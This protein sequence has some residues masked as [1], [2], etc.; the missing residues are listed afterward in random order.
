MPQSNH[1]PIPAPGPIT[2]APAITAVAL[3]GAGPGDPGL[4]TLRGAELLRQ[5]E[6]VVYDHLANPR[7]LAM[8]PTARQIYVGKQAGSHAME[9]DAINA[10]LVA[11]AR[12]GRRVV[13]LKGG[14]P[15][16]FG[17]GGEE[18]QALATAGVPF[19][20]VP[21]ITAAIAA[22][23]YAGIPVTHRDFNSSFTLV[24]GN[25]KE[26]GADSDAESKIDW[27]AL[28]R[29]P[30]I[31]FYM[32][33]AALPRICQR[34][35]EH[36]M[37]PSTPAATIQSGTTGRQRT[38][39]ATLRDLPARVAAAG[40]RAPAI[41]I[42][43][44]VVTLRAAIGWFERRLLFGKTIVVTRTRHQAGELSAKLTE[45]GADVIEA[46]TIELVPPSDFTA[47]DAAL[48]SLATDQGADWVIFTSINGVAAVKARLAAIGLDVRA[49]GRSRIAAIG[50]PTAAAITQQLCLRVDLC[51]EQFVAESLADELEKGGHVAGRR[52]LLLRADITRPVLV[53][54]LRAAGAADVRDISV[55][56]TR[57]AAALPDELRTALRE[58]R[59]D[60]ITFA[61][62]GTATN[63]VALLG[64]DTAHLA[65]IRTASIGPITSATLRQLSLPPTAEAQPSTIDGLIAAIVAATPASPTPEADSTSDS[66]F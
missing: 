30:C 15:F 45:L 41:T 25:E 24:T 29:L 37:D 66:K 7:L 64:N 18:C 5:A 19:E 59:V 36:G 17:R 65:G 57:R 6:V 16:V 49:F 47:V 39:S 14:D 20:V 53:P 44:K 2:P 33:V 35:I 22:A 11:E 32:G 34:L 8:A 51:P 43:G 3:V 4:L 54:R 61:S 38:V 50:Q 12:A 42:V 26:P 48:R 60:W 52:F 27:T 56:E 10:L 21:G 58:K 13:R 40:L 28:A 23:A 1:S 55:Y 62:S 63:F 46:P 31:A 9:Q